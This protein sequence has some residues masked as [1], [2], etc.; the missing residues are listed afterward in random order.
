MH[1]VAKE[2]TAATHLQDSRLAFADYANT[3]ICPLVSLSLRFNG[4]FPG[5]PIEK[6]KFYYYIFLVVPNVAL[7][8]QT[9]VVFVL[10]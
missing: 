4:H 10:C 7:D 2:P 1:M 9:A 3:N 6:I 8:K 5:E